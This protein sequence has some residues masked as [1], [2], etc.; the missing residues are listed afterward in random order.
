MNEIL[1]EDFNIGLLPQLLGRVDPTILEIGANNGGHTRMFFHLFP[2]GNIHSFE[3]DPRAIAKF[4]INLAGYPGAKL[5]EI[6]VGAVDGSAEFHSSG[7]QNPAMGYDM[8][9]GWDLSGSLRKPTGHLTVNPGITFDDK[10]DVKISRLDT[11]R[12]Q[13]QL[14]LIDF[15]WAD[16]QGAEGDLIA[17]GT[18]TFARHVRFLYTEYSDSELYEGQLNL[19]Q[20]LERLPGYSVLAQFRGDV[21]LRNDSLA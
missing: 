15:V 21:L 12:Q 9:G 1:A 5:H 17:G 3:P 13:N 4:K 2:A 16:V 19:P 7:G 18:D 14:G 20:I 6:A 11:W 10:F 8:P